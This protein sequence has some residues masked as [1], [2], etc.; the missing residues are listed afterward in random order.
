MATPPQLADANA[1]LS[2]EPPCPARCSSMRLRRT[3]SI[4]GDASSP[5]SF[6]PRRSAPRKLLAELLPPAQ[7]PASTPRATFQPTRPGGRAED[8][9][10]AVLRSSVAPTH[11]PR[12][13][14]SSIFPAP[15]LRALVVAP[16]QLS[17]AHRTRPRAP[18]SPQPPCGWRA[19]PADRLRASCSPN[20]SHPRKLQ[21]HRGRRPSNPQGRVGRAGDCGRPRA[22]VLRSSVAP[23]PFPAPPAL[24]RFPPPS[25]PATCRG[26]PDLSPA[27]RPGS[28]PPLAPAGAAQTQA[29]ASGNRALPEPR[30]CA[31]LP[32][33]GLR[34]YISGAYVKPGAG[35]YP[36]L[37]RNASPSVSSTLRGP[38]P[39]QGP[40]AWLRCAAPNCRVDLHPRPP[41]PARHPPTRPTAPRLGA[42]R[43][44]RLRRLVLVRASRGASRPPGLVQTPF[45]LLLF[46]AG[47]NQETDPA[48]IEQTQAR[49]AF[50][51]L[52]KR[53]WFRFRSVSRP[54]GGDRDG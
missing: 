22:A 5:A 47:L 29:G 10:R 19:P 23:T 30:P 44:S 49:R 15:L 32:A 33:S 12:R 41:A 54:R 26:I 38:S 36:G 21:L 43:A 42:L 37:P 25:D 16:E 45:P 9:G 4:G 20:C 6:P 35:T 27:L 46:H 53:N 48:A 28:C 39:K 31:P 8:C 50:A 1:P 40:A 51:R 17:P 52:K 24:F 13:P 7:A 14:P 34:L 3:R 18:P 2:C 11:S